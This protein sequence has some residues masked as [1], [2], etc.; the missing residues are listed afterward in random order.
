M[1]E[2][3]GYMPPA[4]SEEWGTPL[5]L[6]LELNDEFEFQLDVAATP[7]NANCADFFTKEQNALI[8]KWKGRCFCNPPYGRK[9]ADWVAKAVE[10]IKNGNAEVVVMLLP[11]RTDVG[12]WHQYVWDNQRHAPRPGVETRFVKGRLKYEVPGQPATPAPFSSVVLVF[13]GEQP[14]T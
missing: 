14:C 1:S 12:W 4:Q 11:S 5:D 10:E 8:Q 3:R 9:I 2:S 6:F 13:R 7:L